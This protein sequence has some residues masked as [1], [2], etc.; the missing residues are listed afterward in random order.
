MARRTG[1]DVS[2]AV[3]FKRRRASWRINVPHASCSETG[4]IEADAEIGDKSIYFHNIM[5]HE[6]NSGVKE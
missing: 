2:R 5:K 3:K 1:I 4:G 6:I